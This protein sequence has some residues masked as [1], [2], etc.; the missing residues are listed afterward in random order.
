MA[1]SVGYLNMLYAF[2]ATEMRLAWKE[3]HSV[4]QTTLDAQEFR[5]THFTVTVYRAGASR[6][7]PEFPAAYCT[8]RL[9]SLLHLL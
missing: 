4:Y 5:V 3:M 6:R 7:I 1:P 8:V 9:L 2:D